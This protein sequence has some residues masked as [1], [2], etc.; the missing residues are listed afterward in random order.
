MNWGAR[1]DRGARSGAGVAIE[2]LE[3]GADIGAGAYLE[4]RYKHLSPL[5]PLAPF[6]LLFKPISYHKYYTVNCI[7]QKLGAQ[8]CKHTNSGSVK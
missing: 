3:K 4:I 7:A 1:M 8:R 2:E 6:L 5:R